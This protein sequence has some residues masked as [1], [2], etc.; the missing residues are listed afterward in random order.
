[1]DLFSVYFLFFIL[2]P[3][4][5]ENS[6]DTVISVQTSQILELLYPLWLLLRYICTELKHFNRLGL[7]VYRTFRQ[8]DMIR[9]VSFMFNM[10]FFII[11]QAN[12]QQ[13]TWSEVQFKR[14]F[15]S[16]TPSM[17]LY[18]HSWKCSRELGLIVQHCINRSH[19]FI[20]RFNLNTAF[21]RGSKSFPNPSITY[22][23][24]N[25]LHLI[26]PNSMWVPITQCFCCTVWLTDVSTNQNP[27][28]L[29]CRGFD[30]GSL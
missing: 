5:A 21:H 23:T 3:S 19:T 25:R 17:M 22:T 16:L 26:K 14:L 6:F 7:L 4:N 12:E 24:S 11:I 18:K 30:L 2:N 15:K 27:R 1:M 29:Y 10:L 9:L 28:A 8:T 20:Y 13:S